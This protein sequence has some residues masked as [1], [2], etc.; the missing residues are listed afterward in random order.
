MSE[1]K[2]V[3]AYKRLI[4]GVDEIIDSGKYRE[5]LRAMKKFHKY[6]F[7]NRILIFSQ[8]PNASQIAGYCTWKKLGRG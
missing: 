7:H 1:I 3:S 8:N 4:E 2:K 5:F 6:S